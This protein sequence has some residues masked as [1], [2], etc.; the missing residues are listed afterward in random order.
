MNDDTDDERALENP[1]Y[2]GLYQSLIDA[3]YAFVAITGG[4]EIYLDHHQEHSIG[5]LA[6]RHGFD[7][8]NVYPMDSDEFGAKVRV[9]HK[10]LARGMADSEERN[11]NE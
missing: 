7:I 5:E 4:A 3:P 1:D 11:Y 9:E 10:D 6:H 2:D 8:S